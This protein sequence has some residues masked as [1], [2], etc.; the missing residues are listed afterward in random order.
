MHSLFS[1][2]LPH[3]KTPR[4]DEFQTGNEKLFSEDQLNQLRLLLSK[5]EERASNPKE[6]VQGSGTVFTRT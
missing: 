3:T 4:L 6:A 2:R 5:R 1:H